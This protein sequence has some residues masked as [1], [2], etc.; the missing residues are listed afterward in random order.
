MLALTGVLSNDYTIRIT[1]DENNITN[2][3]YLVI[4]STKNVH[5]M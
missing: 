1:V 4:K 5:R 2:R 3:S